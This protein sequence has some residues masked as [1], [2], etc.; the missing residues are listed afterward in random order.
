MQIAIVKGNLNIVKLLVEHG[1]D[2]LDA[3]IDLAKA[4]GI[5]RIFFLI[6]FT[7]KIHL[8]KNSIG[9]FNVFLGYQQIT[10]YLQ[11]TYQ[12]NTMALFEAISK[13]IC[14]HDSIKLYKC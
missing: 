14:I 7:K 13:G 6:I 1:A 2:N 3:A 11:Q 10:D 8:G 12:N 4:N 5:L 9:I